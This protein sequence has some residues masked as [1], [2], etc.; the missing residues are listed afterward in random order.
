MR[1]HREQVGGCLCKTIFYYLPKQFF[2]FILKVFQ[3]ILILKIA[4]ERYQIFKKNNL[5]IFVQRKSYLYWWFQNLMR[6]Y[7]WLWFGLRYSKSYFMGIFPSDK[8]HNWISFSFD[9]SFGE[10]LFVAFSLSLMSF[11]IFTNNF[12]PWFFSTR[13]FRIKCFWFFFF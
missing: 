11:F 7:F 2:F 9:K 12:I 4:F 3:Y 5:F 13:R 10:E 8:I 1:Q 6:N